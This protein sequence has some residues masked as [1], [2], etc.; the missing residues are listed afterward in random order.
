[1][2]E[3]D[4]RYAVNTDDCVLLLEVLLNQANKYGVILGL[5][6][7]NLSNIVG[8]KV[9]KIQRIAKILRSL[10]LITQVTPGLSGFFGIQPSIYQLSLN[11]SLYAIEQ[12]RSVININLNYAEKF[13]LP[14]DHLIG[15]IQYLK[16]I[17]IKINSDSDDRKRYETL[18]NQKKLHVHLTAPKY[19]MITYCNSLMTIFAVQV[20]SEND[21][22][23]KLIAILKAG[24]VKD[25]KLYEFRAGVEGNI[26]CLK[27][28]FG[29]SRCTWQGLDKFKAYVWAS[30][31]AYNLLQL[32][33]IQTDI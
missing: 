3:G 8:F 25:K 1:M 21:E 16:K 5:T 30:S 14:S 13:K 4:K 27:R 26:S 19:K 6:R 7:S 33:R 9:A 15:K 22:F 17:D 20:L 23:D 31:V 2:S 24:I 11:H 32:A 28:R 12:Q 18:D 29:L 10:G